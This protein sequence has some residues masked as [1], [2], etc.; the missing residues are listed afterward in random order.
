MIDNHDEI[1]LSYIKNFKTKRQQMTK[2]RKSEITQNMILFS[3][4]VCET[5][6]NLTFVAEQQPDCIIDYSIRQLLEH[7]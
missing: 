6:K 3:A 7:F 2:K 5:F 1:T 4:K